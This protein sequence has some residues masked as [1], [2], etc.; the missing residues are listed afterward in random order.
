MNHDSG[1]SSAN[2][3]T[4]HTIPSYTSRFPDPAAP[5]KQENQVAFLHDAFTHDTT[6]PHGRKKNAGVD[7]K[8]WQPDVNPREA[9]QPA[10]PAAV[11]SMLTLWLDS[12]SFKELF[13]LGH[14]ELDSCLSSL[15]MY[16]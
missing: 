5:A 12:A 7:A 15:I 16:L 8:R 6:T 4:T 2:I 13:G 1:Y 10:D 9:Q 11:N 14:R 3:G